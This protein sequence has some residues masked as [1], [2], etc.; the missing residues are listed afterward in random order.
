[1]AGAAF[2]EAVPLTDVPT[3]DSA[4]GFAGAALVFAFPFIVLIIK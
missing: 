4:A 3:I 1:L 2:V